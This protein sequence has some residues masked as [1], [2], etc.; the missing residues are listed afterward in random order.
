ERL[1]TKMILQIHDELLF[2]VPEEEL[3]NAKELIRHEMES[4]LILSVPL[5]VEL[6][7]GGNW[8]EA[9]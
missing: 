3:G 4:A 6:G 9:H 2:E 1:R 5:K 8:S 7:S